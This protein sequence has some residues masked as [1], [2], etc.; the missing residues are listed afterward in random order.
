MTVDAPLL[1]PHLSDDTLLVSEQHLNSHQC[2][3][4]EI[5]TISG[6]PIIRLARWKLSP[7]GRQRTGQVFEFAAHRTGE[8]AK[9]ISDV[10]AYLGKIDGG[11][12]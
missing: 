5:T 2:F 4:A 6:R 7:A 9:M 1:V 8:V 12:S 3:R 11:R 10:Q